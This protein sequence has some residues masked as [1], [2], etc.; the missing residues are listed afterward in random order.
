M[1]DMAHCT[2]QKHFPVF[3][4]GL[5]KIVINNSH[6]NYLTS[7]TNIMKRHPFSVAFFV[8]ALFII[9]LNPNAKAQSLVETQKL[10]ENANI[11]QPVFNPKEG[12][13]YV[14][15]A[16][17]FDTKGAIYKLDAQT[18]EVLDSIKVPGSAPLG[19]GINVS[20]QTLYSTNSITGLVTAIDIESG[21]QTYISSTVPGSSAR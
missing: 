16:R 2:G 12:A 15:A 17:D 3:I 8:V 10:I 6:F 21:D 9:G 4:T 1:G 19:L 5:F 7:K 14:S 18:L 11:Y 20:T 13:V